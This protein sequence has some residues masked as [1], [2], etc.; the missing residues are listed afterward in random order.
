MTD[1]DTPSPFCEA[2]DSVGNKCDRRAGHDPGHS[3]ELADRGPT[4][5]RWDPTR[6]TE[7][8][9]PAGEYDLV[10]PV[11]IDALDSHGVG[12][13]VIEGRQQ[14]FLRLDHLDPE[15]TP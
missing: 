8:V 9:V 5:T 1:D 11:R 2:P 10:I 6:T 3:W 14:Y 15:P 12:W 4:E 13:R 7:T